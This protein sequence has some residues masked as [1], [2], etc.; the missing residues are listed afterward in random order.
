M[1]FLPRLLKQFT[2]A[3]VYCILRSRKNVSAQERMQEIAKAI[4]LHP[5]D[6]ARVHCIEGDT[7]QPMLGITQTIY[8]ELATKVGQVF[9][10]AANVNF[11]IKLEESRQHNVTSVVN[12]LDFCKRTAALKVGK[13]RLNHVSTSHVCGRRS[14]LLLEQDLFSEHGYLNNYERTK[15]EAEGLIRAAFDEVPA[16]VYRPSQIIGNSQT[17]CVHKFF[18]FYEYL[19]Q[20][21][22]SNL[23]VLV[24]KGESRHDMIPSDFVADGILYLAMQ[25]ETIGKTYHLAAGLKNSLTMNQIIDRVMNAMAHSDQAIKR[26][27]VV[28][29]VDLEST[30][31]EE[32]MQ[33]YSRS[34]Q[35]QLLRT[36]GEFME[37]EFDF[38][39]ATTHATLAAGGISLPDIGAAIERTT[40]YVLNLKVRAASR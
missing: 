22:R 33:I 35:K 25:P 36:Y 7:S 31:T 24:A 8:N 38:D 23:D 12:V 5:I 28:A 4:E 40:E 15:A 10:L 20:S 34:T 16:T 6:A 11:V 2:D 29:K 17:G 9:N 32:E 3:Q 1:A 21:L 19:A 27:R 37:R 14:G 39:V 13:F 30:L 26:P 18:G